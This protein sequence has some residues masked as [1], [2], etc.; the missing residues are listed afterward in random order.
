MPKLTLNPFKWFR[1]AGR[2]RRIAPALSSRAGGQARADAKQREKV[3]VYLVTLQKSLSS[4]Q[5]ALEQDIDIV[6]LVQKVTGD[7]SLIKLEASKTN[8][9]KLTEVA[10]KVRAYFE[11]I[12]EGRLELDAEGIE[13]ISEFVRIF[14]DILGGRTSQADL[15]HINSLNSWD[16]QYQALMAKMKPIVGTDEPADR[17]T[18]AGV[19]EAE[20]CDADATDEDPGAGPET[21][22]RDAGSL[23]RI[24]A[25]IRNPVLDDLIKESAYFD[26]QTHQD[27]VVS[28]DD[29]GTDSA[30]EEAPDAERV[31]Y[32]LPPRD[33]VKDMQVHDVAVHGE[34]EKT[35][36]GHGG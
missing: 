18:D 30:K 8:E 12:A 2:A 17:D 4:L 35:D 25:T 6:W 28:R 21:E 1:R 20:P 5:L 32:D 34:A 24:A 15:S 22:E 3:L 31:S 16:T 14:G 11:T 26:A 23:G 36:E 7:I 33:R 13:M 19:D 9:E 27:S 29:A 10:G